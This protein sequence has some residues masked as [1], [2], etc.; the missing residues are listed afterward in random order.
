MLTIR[1]EQ[2]D[3]FRKVAL[4]KFE[5]EMVEH[6]RK[7]SPR[8]WKVIGDE[9]GRRFIRLGIEHARRYGFTN[10]GPVRFYV[11][12]MFMFG[13]YFDTDP[14]YS[15]AS[16]VLRD[17][18]PVDQTVR[19][20]RL[21]AAMNQYLAEVSGPD[22]RYLIEA[23]RR[24]THL[25]IEDFL[26]PGIAPEEGI[27]EKLRFAYPQ[28]CEFLGEPVLRVVIRHG[29]KLADTYALATDRGRVLMTGFAFAIGHGFPKDPLH[30][31]IGRRLA[32]PKFPSAEDRVNE[33]YSKAL[34]YLSH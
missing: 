31:W 2:A 28:K 14:Q 13:S 11:E 22:Y 8:H 23:L 7:S 15:C 6:L 9:H 4:Q 30:G 21:Y 25:R 27:L 10:R 18:E 32:E 33:L 26:A 16:A 17:A 24:M 5:D 20:D 1:P 29:F 3:T 34:L 19:A 12:L